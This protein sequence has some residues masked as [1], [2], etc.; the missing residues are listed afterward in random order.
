MKTKLLLGLTSVVLLADAALAIRNHRLNQKI[1]VVDLVSR[2]QSQEARPAQP[3]GKM[4]P[5]DEI[6]KPISSAST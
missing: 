1:E 3:Q 4:R 5:F 6:G 2:D